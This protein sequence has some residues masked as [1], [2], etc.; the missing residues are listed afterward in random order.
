MQ[1]NPRNNKGNLQMKHRQ[2]KIKFMQSTDGRDE[3]L[4]VSGLRGLQLV[5]V[6]LLTVSLGYVVYQSIGTVTHVFGRMLIH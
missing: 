5:A 4:V 3:E 1:S 6:V 2:S